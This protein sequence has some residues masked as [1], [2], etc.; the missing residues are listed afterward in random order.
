MTVP[1][2]RPLSSRASAVL[3]ALDLPTDGQPISGV[4]DGAWGGSGPV[5]ETTCPATGEV[6]ARVITVGL[7][8]PSWRMKTVG[9]ARAEPG[10]RSE[11]HRTESRSSR[12]KI[13][14]LR[15]HGTRQLISQGTAKDTQKAIQRS[16]EA[17][18]ALRAMPGPQ[19]GEL[20]RQ[21]REVL[22][23]KTQALGDLVTLEM[24]KIRSEG[25][26]EVQEFVD[27]VR[28]SHRNRL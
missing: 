20:L 24:G 26:G 28:F 21:I 2:A 17:Q 3:K 12:V 15:R 13:E 16:V 1:V 10:R 18:A 23:A 9:G 19:R 11:S 27:I 5:V 8:A 7:S 25:K 22:G 14:D 6:L 4:Y